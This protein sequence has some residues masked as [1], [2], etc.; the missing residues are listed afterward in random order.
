MFQSFTVV[1]LSQIRAQ[2][3]FFFFLETLENRTQFIFHTIIQWFLRNYLLRNSSELLL[4][5][6]A[7]KSGAPWLGTSGWLSSSCQLQQQL[8]RWQ[9]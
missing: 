3:F 6:P 8:Q 1:I 2:A 9:L 5:S 7:W 4:S